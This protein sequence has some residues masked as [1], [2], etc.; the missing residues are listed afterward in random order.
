MRVESKV[1]LLVVQFLC[2]LFRGSLSMRSS[3]RRTQSR[4]GVKEGEERSEVRIHEELRE[5]QDTSLN[6][7]NTNRGIGAWILNLWILGKR[8]SRS[9]GA[10]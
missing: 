6:N 7:W 8:I 2:F 10:G 5:F 1:F 4:C 9:S 3:V